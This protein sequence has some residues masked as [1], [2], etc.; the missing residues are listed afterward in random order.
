MRS[1]IMLLTLTLLYGCASN[2]PSEAEFVTR[3]GVIVGKEVVDLEAGGTET[4]TS[5]VAY[6]WEPPAVAGLRLAWDSCCH[7][8]RAVRMKIHRCAIASS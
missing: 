7:R 5:T 6:R 3:I 4:R 8:H 1:A 2:Q